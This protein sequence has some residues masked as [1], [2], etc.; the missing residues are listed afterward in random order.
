MKKIRIAIM[1]AAAAIPAFAVDVAVVAEKLAAKVTPNTITYK[2]ENGWLYGKNELLHLAKGEL[3]RGGVVKKSACRKPANAD[4]IPALKAFN[5][6]LVKR[7]IKLIVVPVPP[8]IAIEPCGGLRRGEAMVY[9]RPLYQATDH[10]SI[11]QDDC[12]CPDFFDFG[13]QKMLLHITHARGARCYLGDWVMG[14]FVPKYCQFFNFPSGNVFAPRS[15]LDDKGRRL[16]WFWLDDRLRHRVDANR[17]DMRQIWSLPRVFEPLDDGNGLR[18]FVP[19][20]IQSL[21]SAPQDCLAVLPECG[22]PIVAPFR[23]RSCKLH[24]S[25]KLAKGKFSMD[26]F[27]NKDG[28]E[29]LRLIVDR[30]AQRLVLDHSTARY[31][32]P[33]DIYFWV[34]GETNPQPLRQEIPWQAKHLF[35]QRLTSILVGACS[36]GALF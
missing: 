19:E 8:K 35:Q 1:F 27:S 5:D 6:A 34:P 23:S 28:A 30:E 10:F 15:L 13:K 4:P 36:C 9:L 17:P 18:Q 11:R 3:A 12:S 20:E 24:V 16:V 26:V 2:A 33:N 29:S 31:P 25:L 21:C 14:T 7:G 32:L 22:K